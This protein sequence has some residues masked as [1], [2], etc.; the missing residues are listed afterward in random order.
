MVFIFIIF[1][2]WNLEQLAVAATVT[3][4]I[5]FILT[6]IISSQRSSKVNVLAQEQEETPAIM[7]G[8]AGLYGIVNGLGITD[9]LYDYGTALNTGIIS[10]APWGLLGIVSIDLPHTFRLLAFLVT[11]IPFIHGA[12]LTTSKKW[13][14]SQ[15]LVAFVFFI[16]IFIH[17]ILF[18][19]AALNISKI[20]LFILSLWIIMILNSVWIVIQGR[21]SGTHDIFLK[22]WFFLNFNTFAFLSVFV[23]VPA[24]F[25]DVG[26]NDNLNLL[27]LLVMV[28]RSITDYIVGWKR[29]YN[30]DPAKPAEPSLNKGSK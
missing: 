13:H 4:V 14:K 15:H 29:L 5:A 7:V 28:S 2:P 9:A 25:N 23:F 6:A 18:Y 17:A 20:P 30:R 24:N 21:I 1:T 10:S 16:L 26:T 8:I 19:F 12:I 3:C 22:E 27:I 11:I